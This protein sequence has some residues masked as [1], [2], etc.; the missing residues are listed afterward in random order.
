MNQLQERIAVVDVL[1]A[2]ALFG[3]MV[4]HAEFE[5]LAGP[6][7]SETFGRVYAFDPTITR[8]VDI[9]VNGKFFAIFSFLFG[10][11]FAIQLD[12][13]ARK[14]AAFA[15]RFAWRL[16]VLFLIGLVHQAFFT[17]D[18]LMIY[19]VVG[20]LLI[21]LR[22]V[23]NRVLLV[24]AGR[25]NLFRDSAE[26]RARM[27]RLLVVGG[28]VALVTSAYLLVAGPDPCRRKTRSKYSA[29]SWPVFNG[30]RLPRST[31]RRWRC[32]F[33]GDL[34]PGSCPRWRPSDAWNLTTLPHVT[35]QILTHPVTL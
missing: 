1:R 18:I 23:S 3:I 11:S 13:A 8:L 29:D 7:P 24:I 2:V 25:I 9:L 17:G 14:G 34:A 21:P 33:G 4:A 20:M 22:N 16:A 10:L 26:S 15:G 12:N 28:A 30:S 6:T 27:R 35:I 19:A 31:L 32:C 5:F